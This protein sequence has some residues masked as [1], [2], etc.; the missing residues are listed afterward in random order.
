MKFYFYKPFKNILQ[1][2]NEQFNKILG[3]IK[4]G[5]KQGAKLVAGGAR[6]GNKGYFI[7][8]TV[9]SD[10]DDSMTIAQEEASINILI[11]I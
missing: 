9:F 6:H 10:V 8:P 7:E 2:D 5:N 11:E 1:V 4:T 3:L